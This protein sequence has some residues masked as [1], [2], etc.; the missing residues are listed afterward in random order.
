MNLTVDLFSIIF[1]GCLLMGAAVADL[2]F[3]KIPNLFTYPAMVVALAYHGW[4]NGMGG[5]FF[6]T[7]GL[8]LGIGI[9]VAPYL[10]G[11]VGAGDA[12][13]MGAV[14][15]ILGPK[16][17]LLAFLFTAIF[18]GIYGLTLLLA[19]PGYVRSFMKRWGTALKTLIRVGQFIY[20]PPTKDQKKPRLSYGVVIALGT[21]CSVVWRLSGHRVPI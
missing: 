8:V 12:K 7:G 17:V 6:S 14:G 13:L 2:R 18:G 1:L 9:L 20:I 11:G 15:S 10:T 4:T 5:L 21:I 19:K 16:G 3:Q